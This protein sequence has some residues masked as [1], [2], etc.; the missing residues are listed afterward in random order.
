MGT[1]KSLNDMGGKMELA[2]KNIREARRSSLAATE[3]NMRPRFRDEARQAAGGNRILSG[4]R[5]KT[6]LDASFKITDTATNSYLNIK[7]VGPWG[8][9]DNTDVGGGTA[10]HLIMPRAKLALRFR[11]LDGQQIIRG[12]SFHPG[13]SREPFWG[14][15]R[16]LSFRF[17]QTRIPKDTIAAIEAALE[18]S[19]FK[20]RG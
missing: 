4:M 14:R 20:S 18:H 15:A 11:D 7:P 16:S 17:V 13:S 19:G 3:R 10:S 2:A 1:S 6:A 12:F 9:R 5:N 8:I